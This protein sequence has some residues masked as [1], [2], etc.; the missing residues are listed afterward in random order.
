MIADTSVNRMEL[1]MP[2][3][4]TAGMAKGFKLTLQ[5]AAVTYA[6]RSSDSAQRDV[7]GPI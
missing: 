5:P 3:N 6:D 1:A 7:S 4:V 2:Q